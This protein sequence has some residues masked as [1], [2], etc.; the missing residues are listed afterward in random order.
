[1]LGIYRRYILRAYGIMVIIVIKKKNVVPRY[2]CITYVYKH[3]YKRNI[4]IIGS[5][6]D[7]SRFIG[8][9][10]R[11]REPII[12]YYVGTSRYYYNY[13]AFYLYLHKRAVYRVRGGSIGRY[14][15]GTIKI[16]YDCIT[17][18]D[19]MEKYINRCNYIME[20]VGCNGVPYC[21]IYRTYTHVC[22]FPIPECNTI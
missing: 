4:T 3:R 9:G 20:T 14:T 11:R 10:T 13:I 2:M 15:V 21:R 16:K 18:C 5:T 6:A 22:S 17:F 1:M 8:W 7:Q 12:I 19:E